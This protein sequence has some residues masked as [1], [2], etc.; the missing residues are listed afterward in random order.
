[1][2]AGFI[3]AGKV[4]CS[5][6]KYF[7]SH[8][9][10]V[11]GYYD[12]DEKAA[13]EAAKFTETN[14]VNDISSLVKNSDTLF[15]T[16]PDGLITVVWNQIK[17]ESLSGKFIIHCSGALSAKE[18]FPGI[19]DTGAF[20]YSVHPL[21]AVSDK[22]HSYEELK[23]AYFT[24]EGDQ[25]HLEEVQ[26]TF[27]GLGNPI[28]S[29]SAEDKV[30]YH[31]AAAVCS[32]HMIALLQETVDLLLECGFKEQDA[33]NAISPIVWANVSHVLTK[34][35]A[36]SLTGPVERADRETVKKH[37][38]CLKDKEKDRELYKL[39]SQ[40]LVAIGKKKNP[41]RDYHQLEKILE[42]QG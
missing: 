41:E 18:A 27:K 7:V 6:G 5:L 13:M 30:K 28:L 33:L 23:H 3:G 14:F 34:G 36:A 40:R 24:I 29:L 42:E 39:L 15:L 38:Q 2:K 22:Y 35:A 25:K 20:G 32:N 26:E 8:D 17:E 16:V 9:I 31:L 19:A 4:G 21:F 11:M 10:E 12:A 37:L 1:M